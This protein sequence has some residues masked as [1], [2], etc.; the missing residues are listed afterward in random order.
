MKLPFNKKANKSKIKAYN[1]TFLNAPYYTH[2]RNPKF[3]NSIQGLS[4]FK[5]RST[6][7]F[8]FMLWWNFIWPQ[9]RGENYTILLVLTGYHGYEPELVEHNLWTWKIAP[10]FNIREIHQIWFTILKYFFSSTL[11]RILKYT[12]ILAP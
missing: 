9:I 8:S 1:L 5:L 3:L 11:Y 7:S 10:H 6:L 12:A 4:L 2:H